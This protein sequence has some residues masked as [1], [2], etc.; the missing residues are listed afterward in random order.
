MTKTKAMVAAGLFIVITGIKLVTPA[1]AAEVRSFLLPQLDRDTDYKAAMT[2]LGERI[3]GEDGVIASL[4]RLTGLVDETEAEPAA[5]STA[6]YA[7][8]PE[9]QTPAEIREDFRSVIPEYLRSTQ[10]KEEAAA[11]TL[12][13]QV[14]EPEA[15]PE[16]GAEQSKQSE[17]VA[18]FIE[19]QREFGEHEVPANVTYDMPELGLDYASPVSGWSSSGFGYRLHPIE[20]EVKF[21]YGTDFAADSG[22]DIGAF[23]DGTVVTA[24]V[25]DS[26][27]NYIVLSHEGGFRTLYAHCGALYVTEGE[28]VSKGQLIALVSSTGLAT[29]P[30]LH[31]E[32]TLDSIY[33]NPEYYV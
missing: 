32:L 31:F 4:G 24:G 10:A 25:S 2:Q 8:K 12:A 29:G 1:F 11:E 6:S 27:G 17:A 18:A 19:S 28:S 13:V 15:E 9:L 26:F 30:H 7:D 33:L 23:A 3:T 22:T 21:H 16:S 14:P 5:K 20:G